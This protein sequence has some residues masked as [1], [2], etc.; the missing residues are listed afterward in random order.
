MESKEC[1][2]LEQQS[3]EFPRKGIKSFV[4]RVGRVTNAQQEALKRFYDKH[5]LA[6]DSSEQLDKE[7]IFGRI[8]P[9]VFEIGFGN[10]DSLAKMAAADPD[11]DYI[12]IEV[13]RPGIGH[14]LNL[15]EQGNLSNVKIMEGD[16]VEV[17]QNH[18]PDS[19]L[20]GVQLFFPDPWP[21]KRHFK[22]RIVQPSWVNKIYTKL[23]KDGF[24]HMATDWENYAEHM[25]EVLEADGR[26]VN[27][28]GAGNFAPRP[29]HRP[30]TK[31][32]R[33]G[34]NLGHG[35]WDLIYIKK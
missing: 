35:V 34:I 5:S 27:Q 33:R 22:R 23:E 8:A 13:H 32:E 20:H 6:P 31:F 24:L 1:Q 21:K 29:A 25:L 14:L 15:I 12:G 3:T 18:F 2:L 7:A 9:V 4:K 30:E 16:A 28:N 11:K 10:G 26:F 17:L 19:F